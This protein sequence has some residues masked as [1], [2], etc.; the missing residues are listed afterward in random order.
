MT[1]RVLLVDDQALLRQGLHMMLAAE[2]DM[3]VVA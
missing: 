1:I 2:P 3:D